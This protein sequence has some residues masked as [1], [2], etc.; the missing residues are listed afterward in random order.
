[1]FLVSSLLRAHKPSYDNL[2]IGRLAAYL[3]N[4]TP[5]VGQHSELKVWLTTG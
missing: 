2:W 4:D 3:E 5:D 1:M